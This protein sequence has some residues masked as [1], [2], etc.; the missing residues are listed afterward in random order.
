MSGSSLEGAPLH[1]TVGFTRV[2]GLL[3]H[4]IC[5]SMGNWPSCC[6]RRLAAD[7]WRHPKNPRLAL[8]PL[9]CAAVSTWC[10]F[11]SI[12]LPFSC[13]SKQASRFQIPGDTPQQPSKNYRALK[14]CRA[15]GAL[16]LCSP[17]HPPAHIAPTARRRRHAARPTA[18]Q[19][20][21]R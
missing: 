13:G 19:W 11:L 3:H 7:Q 17:C 8:S 4:S 14:N 9:G 10:F 21:R 16:K 2:V 20:R 18:A 5:Q 12:S 6:S 1:S 15:L